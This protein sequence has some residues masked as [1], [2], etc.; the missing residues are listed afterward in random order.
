ML[1]R[2]FA[3]LRSKQ[4]SQTRFAPLA[5]NEPFYAVGDVHGCSALL[6]GL[7]AKF[8]P[9]L[10][11]VMVGDYVD[12]GDDSR[13]VLTMLMDRP[14]TT[15]LRGNHEQM[16]IDYLARPEEAGARFL[17][18]GGLQTLASFGIGGVQP[19]SEPALLADKAEALRAAMGQPMIDWLDRLPCQFSSGNVAVVHAGA[20]PA[21]PMDL[22]APRN[23]MW[24][25]RDF[26]SKDRSDGLWIIHGHTIVPSVDIEPGRIAIDTGA[27]A[28]GRLSAVLVEERGASVLQS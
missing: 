16:L 5:P 19:T 14:G 6:A 23:L 25:H 24:G 10:P 9:A 4:T 7:L 28:T 22:Q 26:P 2:L 11:V 18:N 3:S 8:D 17:R 27:Y 15:C 1:G 13:G 12:R 21:V 20:D